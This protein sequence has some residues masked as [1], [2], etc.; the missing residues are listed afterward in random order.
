M[1]FAGVRSQFPKPTTADAG[2][3]IDW[4][5]ADRSRIEMG[6]N[7]GHIPMDKFEALAKHNFETFGLDSFRVV[8]GVRAGPRVPHNVGPHDF[9][10]PV[11]LVK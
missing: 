8:L 4:Q 7:L 6:G 10:D 5:Q 9:V 1:R 2:S 11:Y 3:P